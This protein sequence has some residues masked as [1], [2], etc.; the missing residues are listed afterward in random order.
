VAGFAG[1]LIS[2]DWLRALGGCQDVPPKLPRVSCYIRPRTPGAAVFFTVTLAGR[3]SRL[4]VDHVATLREAVRVTKAERPFRIDA[5]V[6]LPDHMHCLWTLPEGDSDYSVRMGA[7]K[8]RFSRALP[9]GRMRASH[10]IRRET[11]IW[12]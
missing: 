7:I 2:R 1:R 3:G 6:V 8:V 4:L 12:Q 9:E 10:I 11:G 5:W